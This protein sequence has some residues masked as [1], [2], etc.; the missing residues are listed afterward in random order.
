[1]NLDWKKLGVIALFISAVFLF[2]FF[3]YF[4]FFKPLTTEPKPTDINANV[5]ADGQLP[6]TVNIN[7]RLFAV[8]TNGQLPQLG[9]GIRELT[10]PDVE[11]SSLANGGI[12]KVTQI[13]NTDSFFMIASQNGKIIYYNPDD[14]KF[15]IVSPDGTIEEFDGKEFHNVINATF[16]GQTDKAI[17]EYPDGSN[18][19]Y[20][21]DSGK[22][23]TLPQHWYEFNFSPTDQQIAF[24][25]SS[26][27]PQN[28]FLVASDIDGTQPI[29]L[30]NIGDQGNKFDVNWSPNNQM[31]A[32]FTKGKDLD[33]SEVYFI[34]KNDEN[35]KLMT[36]EGRDFRG[37]W[38]PD[39]NK[40][41][42][43]AYSSNNDYKPQ[44]WVSDT[45]PGEIGNNRRSLGLNTW[46]NK[47]TFSTGGKAYCAV[48]T[49]M[50]YGAGMND[51]STD[52]IPDQIYE[53]DLDTGVK[54]LIA[55]P[56]GNHVIDIMIVDE[57]Y[58]QLFFTNKNNNRIYKINL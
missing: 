14:G 6:V 19:V 35:F 28:R 29:I 21:F 15:Y 24:K 41:I 11:P 45:S 47:C 53:I 55:I 2:A 56:E 46:A 48:P 31:V 23:I 1:M 50:P 39:G 22:Q 3:I 37:L 44:L 26:L 12:T 10:T 32:T 7:G 54:K 57:D 58:N 13:T 38:S 34:G 52:N 40:M 33:R 4:F 51:S 43:S 17:L 9:D 16:T 27:D 42:Y 36:I 5:P 8:N 18:I 25:S 20:D 49:I 30:E